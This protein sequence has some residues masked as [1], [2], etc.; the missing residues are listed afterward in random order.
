MSAKLLGMLTTALIIIDVQKGYLA[1]GELEIPDA[2][3]ILH[4][5]SLAAHDV[6][7]VIVSRQL[8]EENDHSFFKQGGIW[9]PHMIRGTKGAQINP[10]MR[11]LANYTITTGTKP[12][13]PDDYSIFTGSTLRPVNTLEQLLDKHEIERVIITGFPLD[14]TVKFTALDANALGYDTIVPLDCTRAMTHPG[15]LDTLRVFDRAG[16]KYRDHWSS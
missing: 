5:I 6:D 9:P 14:W 1:G 3:S 2:N 12:D 8:H 16:V 4:P 7:L 15:H 10:K 11:K 13:G